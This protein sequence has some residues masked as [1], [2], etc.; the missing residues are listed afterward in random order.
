MTLWQFIKYGALV[1]FVALPAA[2]LLDLLGRLASR[3]V[4]RRADAHRRAVER[5]REIR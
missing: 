5:E 2:A 3:G 1:V 4:E